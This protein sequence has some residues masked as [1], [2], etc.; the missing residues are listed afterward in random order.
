MWRCIGGKCPIKWTGELLC[1]SRSSNSYFLNASKEFL[2]RCDRIY[3]SCYF[4]CQIGESLWLTSDTLWKFGQ[5]IPPVTRKPPSTSTLALTLLK[6]EGKRE[7]KET[8]MVL[9]GGG[10]GV[11]GQ[12][13]T[14]S[15]AIVLPPPP[16]LPHLSRNRNKKLQWPYATSNKSRPQVVVS[17]CFTWKHLG[18]SIELVGHFI[19]SNT[20]VPL[21]PF[22]NNL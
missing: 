18:Y 11:H 12:N 2:R 1:L 13:V 9:D 16:R 19:S 22:L 8:Q 17:A 10:H 14:C 5:V 7:R 15:C 6:A 20:L 3:L 21:F 4:F